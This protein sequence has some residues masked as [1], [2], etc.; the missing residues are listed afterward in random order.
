M[1]IRFVLVGTQ[2]PGNIGSAARAMKVMGFDELRLVRPVDFPSTDATA[3]AAGAADVLAGAAVF[4]SVDQAVADCGLVVGT[5][6]RT[7]E[8][9]WRVDDPR[10][11]A[12]ELVQSATTTHVAILFGCERTG[13][14]NA[15]LEQCHR[16]LTIPTSAGYSSLNLAMA[17]QI[18]AYELWVARA[19]DAR[20]RTDV[21]SVPLASAHEM[22]RFYEHLQQVLDEIGFHDRTGEGHLFA[23]LR[24]LFNRACLDE[25]EVHIL[26]GILTAVQGRRRRAG[27][28]HGAAAR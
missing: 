16:L 10:S 5:T 4:D 20:V 22:D 24:R 2:H 8:S 11:T 17:V 13:L 25:N 15:E 18:V 27:D 1:S 19:S 28:P 23:R 7:R 9:A 6:A 3:M 14:E 12:S 21:R 26:R